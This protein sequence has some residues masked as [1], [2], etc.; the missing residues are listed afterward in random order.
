LGA[1]AGCCGLRFATAF[2]VRRKGSQKRAKP[3]ASLARHHE[4]STKQKRHKKRLLKSVLIIIIR[5]IGGLFLIILKRDFKRSKNLKPFSSLRT[6]IEGI[7]H[8]NYFLH[9]A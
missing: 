8:P 2:F 3:Y 1:R 6:V 7:L 4:I 9:K 5:V